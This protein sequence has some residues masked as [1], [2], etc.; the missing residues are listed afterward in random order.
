MTVDVMISIP[1]SIVISR[2]RVL[3]V[4]MDHDDRYTFILCLRHS[5]IILFMIGALQQ[6]KNTQC[7]S[8]TGNLDAGLGEN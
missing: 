8:Y 4:R 7:K 1:R 3:A 2:R 6:Y 5:P